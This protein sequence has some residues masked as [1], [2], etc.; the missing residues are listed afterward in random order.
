MEIDP[1]EPP[2][3][4]STPQPDD[5]AAPQP[6]E[7]SAHGWTF[8]DV[9]F[10][11]GF[12]FGAQILVYV[13]ALLALALLGQ[14]RGGAL[15]L[16]DVAAR[17]SFVLPVQFAWWAV[18]FWVIYR[19]V[20]ARDPRPFRE[21]IG[22]VRPRLPLGVYFSSGALLALS[23]AALA[24][25]LPSPKKHTPMEQLFRDPLSAVLLA[26][27]GV[28][29]APA[30]EELL[31]RGFLYP[32]VARM[33]GAVAAVLS[34]AALFSLVHAPQ[35]GWAWQNIL[36]LTYVG[37]V[38]GAIRAWSGSLIPSTLVH[39]AYNLTLFA[40]LFASTKGFRNFTF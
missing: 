16:S 3:P 17:A 40:G 5:G 34:T 29:I 12:A 35:Y 19:V 1:A 10:V 28:L 23:V 30:I 38:F 14:L 21:A 9:I 15:T 33:Y 2:R 27:F 26:V 39:A 37:V 36:L 18:V 11:A 8:A 31:F 25:L 7:P 6:S 24:W 32:V 4:D 13:V 20:R 22:W